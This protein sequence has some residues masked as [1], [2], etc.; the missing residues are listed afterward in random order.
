MTQDQFNL[1]YMTS[2]VTN[3]PEKME[4]RSPGKQ[5]HFWRFHFDWVIIDMKTINVWPLW[6]PFN[7][8][9]LGFDIRLSHLA[10]QVSLF[11]CAQCFQ[12]I[13]HLIV[14]IWSLKFV[15]MFD[16][17]RAVPTSFPVD[18]NTLGWISKQRFLTQSFSHWSLGGAR[19]GQIVLFHGKNQ[20]LN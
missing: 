6:V 4:I 11:I 2:T 7:V 16:I 20:I 15:N 18:R 13:S 19:S 9:I 5:K 3:P 8:W 17:I 12:I 14:S 1:Q 10:F